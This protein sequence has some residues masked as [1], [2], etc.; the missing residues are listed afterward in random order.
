MVGLPVLRV[1]FP[2]LVEYRLKGFFAGCG[3]EFGDG[4]ESAVGVVVGDLGDGFGGG[5]GGPGEVAA[6]DLEAVEEEPG[7]AGVK[8]VGGD[9]TQDLADGGLNGA[10]IFG[11]GQVEGIG[12]VGMRSERFGPAGGVVVVAK[13][14]FTERFAAATVAIGEDVTALIDG[15]GVRDELRHVRGAPTPLGM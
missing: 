11:E 5:S 2:L 15:I 3:M 14:F 8:G 10:A 6:C 7:A 1:L 12:E 13:I 4:G 9:A